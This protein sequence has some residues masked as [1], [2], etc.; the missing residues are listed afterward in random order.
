M[1]LVAP[2]AVT[3]INAS[4]GTP[5]HEGAASSV[6][7]VDAR[8]AAVGGE[9]QPGDRVVDLD[10]DRLLPGLINAHDHLQLNGFPPL[11]CEPRF[12]NVREWIV[13]VSL[14]ARTDAA[15]RAVVDAP[16]DRRLLHGGVKNLLSGVTTVAHHDPLYPALMDAGFPTRV[17]EHYGWSH[18]LGIDDESQVRR[19]YERTP[20]HVPWIIHA[21]EGLDDEAAQELDRLE[22]LGCLGMNTL[23]VHGVALGAADRA[24]LA[25][26]GAGLVW[27][28]ASNLQLFGRSAEVADLVARGGVAL[29]TDSRLS[30]ARDL[31]RELRVARAV[32]GLDDATL[33]ALVTESSARLLRLADRG[34]LEAGMLADLLVLPRALAL[35]EADRGDVRMVVVGGRMRYGD[36]DY[37]RAM[38]PASQWLDVTVDGRGKALDRALADRLARAGVHEPGLELPE[39]AWRA[40]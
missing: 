40:A 23:I 7:V 32:A 34:G 33:Q 21:A 28:P 18:S 4:L 16:R 27:C 8:I 35:S 6:R 25:D 19:S 20:K 17:V 38:G 37:A 13:E 5:V 39:T 30:G 10:G 29:G 2:R 3:F 15:F 14:R 26:V 22:T 12:R 11:E 1:T 31:L 24:R 9:P 36:V